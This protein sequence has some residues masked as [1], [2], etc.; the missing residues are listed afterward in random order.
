MQNRSMHHNRSGSNV[1]P[2]RAGV[3]VDSLVQIH[4]VTQAN[5]V[6]KPQTNAAFDRGSAVHAQDEAIEQTAQSNTNDRGNPS[7]QKI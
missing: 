2:T 4:T 1:Y 3:E 7:K 5:V 6:R